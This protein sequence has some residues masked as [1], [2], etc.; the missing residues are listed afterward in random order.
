MNRKINN[1]LRFDKEQKWLIFDFETEN[2][3]LYQNKPFQLSWILV[4]GDNIL[5]E[6]DHYLWFNDLEVSAGAAIVNKFN[7]D[8]YKKQAKDPVKILKSFD[9]LLYNQEILV[10]GANIIGFDI[11]I[12]ANLRRLLGF[13]KDYSWVSRLI[14]CQNLEKAISLG[15]TIPQEGCLT[16]WN[17]KLYSYYNKSVKT[18]VQTLCKKYEI[19]Y[20]I[21]KAH[22]GLY[23]VK[24][25][26]EI[27]KKQL[28]QVNI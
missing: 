25:C 3:N 24:L 27:L 21:N 17:F 14:D 18:S 10:S 23:D 2:L 16:A 20:D 15:Y 26:Y 1:L 13:K 8:V 11:Y 22:N 4:A 5:D 12:H 6:Q 19:T 28:Y 9:S 7:Y